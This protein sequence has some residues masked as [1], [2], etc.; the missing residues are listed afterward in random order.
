MATQIEIECPRCGGHGGSLGWKPDFGICYRCHGNKVVSV[1]V[2]RHV[3]ALHH[4]RAQYVRLRSTLRSCDAADVDCVREALDFC[5]QD[6]L[7]VRGDLEAA[8]VL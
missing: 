3:A 7:R 2:D 6:G 8:G 4:L 1:D 5:V